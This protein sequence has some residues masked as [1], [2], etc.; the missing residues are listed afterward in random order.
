VTRDCDPSRLQPEISS[1]I[2]VSSTTV[3]VYDLRQLHLRLKDREHPARK[4]R[5]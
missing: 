4:I 5:K 2:V 3:V 1:I